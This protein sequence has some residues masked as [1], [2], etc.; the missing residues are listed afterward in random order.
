MAKTKKPASKST[1]KVTKVKSGFFSKPRNLLVVAFIAIFALIGGYNVYTST[2][3]STKGSYSNINTCNYFIQTRKI[4]SMRVGTEGVCVTTLG[5]ALNGIH[6]AHSDQGTTKYWKS[7]NA[8]TVGANGFYGSTYKS[9]VLG[10]QKWQGGKAG[11]A[12]GIAGPKTWTRISEL[13]YG[14]K[15]LK[16]ACGLGY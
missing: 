15:T 2:A 16:Y 1:K 12:D 4:P 10:F 6:K 11:P 9:A 7:L 5:R 13:C 14:T 8:P 3:T